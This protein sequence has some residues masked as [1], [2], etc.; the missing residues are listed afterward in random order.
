MAWCLVKHRENF[1][2][3]SC[4][5]SVLFTLTYCTVQN[6]SWDANSHS[7][8]QKFSHLLWNPKA[9][10]CVHKNPSLVPVLSQMNLVNTFWT[11]ALRSILILSPDLSLGLPNRLLPTGFLTKILHIFLIYPICATC[12]ANLTLLD[13]ITLTVSGEAYKLWSSS[14][15]SLL[16]SPTA[17]SPL[18]RNIVLTTL[19]CQ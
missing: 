16:Q 11:Y 9:Y 18:G 17:S 7:S 3:L 8:S 15:R 6:L 2:F 14:L 12:P 4:R 13:L 1:T 10:H 5:W 19:W